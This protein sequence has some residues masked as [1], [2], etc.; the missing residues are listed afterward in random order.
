MQTE[1]AFAFDNLFDLLLAG[2]GLMIPIGLCSVVALGYIVERSIRLSSGRLG[3]ERLARELRELV[4]SQGPAAGLERCAHDRSSLARVVEAG[5]RRARAPWLEREKAVED[6]GSREVERL[7]A[8]LKPLVVISMIAPLLGLLGTVW[9][10]I[11]AF[12]Q[13]GLGQGLGKPEAL[14]SGISLA[15]VTTAAGLAVAIPAQAAYYWFRGRIDRF[16]R[17]TEDLYVELSALLGDGATPGAAFGSGPMGARGGSSGVGVAPAAAVGVGG[18]GVP[19][20]ADGR[21]GPGER[22]A[23]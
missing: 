13:I 4:A 3:S 23:P 14:A 15:L 21:G 2:G 20:P 5:L 8:N 1:S 17:R 10:M 7:S 19:G 22:R 6:A 16:V 12:A 11:Q 18:V 9:G